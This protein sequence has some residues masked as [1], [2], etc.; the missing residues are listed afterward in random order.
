[1]RVGISGSRATR[2]GERELVEAAFSVFTPSDTIITGA[3]VGIDAIAARVACDRGLYVVTIVPD[4]RHQV[5]EDWSDWCHEW[6]EMP[7]GS[8][9][10]DRNARIVK[11]CDLLVAFPN[12]GEFHP[13]STRSGTWQT[14]RLCRHAG[15]ETK[16]IVVREEFY[17]PKGQRA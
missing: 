1:M 14:I 9:F 3:A 13:A 15:K 6:I 5:D 10:R 12:Y 17:T 4:Q 11:E 16:V 8:T 2:G 7:V